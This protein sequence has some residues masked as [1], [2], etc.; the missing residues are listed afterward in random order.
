MTGISRRNFLRTGSGALG[1]SVTAGLGV[2]PA[3]ADG[4][5]HGSA[6]TPALIWRDPLDILRREL[7]GQLLVPG[8]PGFEAAIKPANGRYQYVIPVAAAK[9]A[10][11]RDV[12][13]C[14]NWAKN[15]GVQPMGRTGGHSYAGYS[16]T[17]GL[18]ID[19]GLLNSVRI[20][21]ENGTA[22]VGGGALNR[23]VFDA[24]HKSRL[25]LPAGTCL[26][27][28]VGGLT[29]GGGIGYNT[30]WQGLT[31]D[32]LRS[33]QIVTASGELLDLDKAQNSDLFW[34]CQGGAGGSFGLN[35][36]FVFD[37]AEVPKRNVAFY[38]FEWRGADAATAVLSTFDQ[39]LAKAPAAFNAVAQAQAVPVTRPG[40]EREA[41]TVF[42]RGQYIG[43]LDELSDIVRPLITAAGHP[44]QRTIK[45]MTFCEAQGQFESSDETKTH[46][47]GDLS[48]YA[49]KP[50]PHEVVDQ[51]VDLLAHCPARSADA[52]GSL[53]S[54]GWIG[55]PIVGGKRRQ[56]TAYVHRDMHTLWRPTPVWPN[57][58]PPQV[59]DGLIGWTN[60]VIEL[61]DGHTPRE[62][63]QN[64]PNGQI[65]DWPA[66]Y[67][68]E[69][70]PRLVQVKAAYDRENLFRNPQSIPPQRL[71]AQNSAVVDILPAL[72]QRSGQVMTHGRPSRGPVRPHWGGRRR[73]PRRAG[74]LPGGRRRPRRARGSGLPPSCQSP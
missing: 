30:H 55:G 9:C 33:A 27:V 43:P 24:T 41:I 11:E 17:T 48:R 44:S 65:I 54:L 23:H 26:D 59:G 51:M 1:L 69:N 53:W 63:Y 74:R 14:V 58:A 49:H 29:L 32:H 52:N 42:S 62:S 12:I 5:A 68:A 56:D 72:G 38:K 3:M 10:D 28:G 25:F 36:Q 31:C 6:G 13:T 20:D 50:L 37:L 66:Q 47:F 2:R 15:F 60:A 7:K 19:M 39:V 4:L 8:D 21:H 45:E 16:T 22:T 64:F 70:Y 67:Y 34:A 73:C 40:G 46:S 71:A 18:I 61:L 35:T 57:N